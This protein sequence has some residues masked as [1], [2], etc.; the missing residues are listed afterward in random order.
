MYC[1]HSVV[2]IILQ[3]STLGSF[4]M[5]K[6]CP[7]LVIVITQ[8]LK[9]WSNRQQRMNTP[10]L[11]E[12]L[13]YK[14]QGQSSIPNKVRWSTFGAYSYMKPLNILD[15][16]KVVLKLSHLHTSIKGRCFHRIR[17]SKYR[18]FMA[19]IFNFCEETFSWLKASHE[20]STPTM[21]LESLH[22]VHSEYMMI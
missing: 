14:L 11:L 10:L 20:N 13:P 22:T 3:W 19:A 18:M 21:G 6:K 9:I 17:L 16:F 4:H 2:D 7:I 12:P 15:T 8:Y 1:F 5:I